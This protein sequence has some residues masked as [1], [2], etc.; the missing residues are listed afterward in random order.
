MEIMEYMR[1]LQHGDKDETRE[2]NFPV[3]NESSSVCTRAH[4]DN[5]TLEISF[6]PPPHPNNLPGEIRMA[7]DVPDFKWRYISV[8]S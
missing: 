6:N 8:L 5:K 4:Y 2:I 3:P 7:T 1:V